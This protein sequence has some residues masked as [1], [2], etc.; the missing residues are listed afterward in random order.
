MGEEI[1]GHSLKEVIMPE[2]LVLDTFDFMPIGAAIKREREARGISRETL[3][4]MCDISAGY[5]KDIENTG[6][7]PGFQV[8]WKLVTLFDI[9]VDEYFYPDRVTATDSRRRKIIG[10]IHE[11]GSRDVYLLEDMVKGMTRRKNPGEEE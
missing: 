5:V 10:M 11:V 6:R 7:H 2:S 8:F 3:A 9:S 4:E 1:S